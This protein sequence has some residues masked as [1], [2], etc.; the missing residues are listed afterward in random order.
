MGRL[1]VEKAAAV[2]VN[3][4]RDSGQGTDR[5]STDRISGHRQGIRVPTGYQGTGRVSGYQQDTRAPAG[6]QEAAAPLR[7]AQRIHSTLGWTDAFHL[8]LYSG[9]L[10]GDE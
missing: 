4:V 7:Y 8:H 1:V 9:C 6:Y 10:E 3:S 5:E 2:H